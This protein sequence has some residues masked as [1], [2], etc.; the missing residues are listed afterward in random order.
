MTVLA[1]VNG[2]A[3]G[4]FGFVLLITL[5]ITYWASKRTSTA[6]DFWA[7]GRGITGAQN[8]FAIAGDYMSAASFL[9][10]AGLIY[11]YGFDGF[12]YSVGFLVA[13]LTV[14]FL[15][16]ERMRNAGKFTIADVLAFRLRQEPARVAAATGTLAVVAFYLIAQMVGAGLLIEALAGIDYRLAV[17]VTGTFMLVYVI[18]GGMIATTWVQIVK[19]V[20]L[21]AGAT[22][23]TVLVLGKVGFNPIELFNRAEREGMAEGSEFSLAPGTFLSSPLDT[24]SLGLALVLGTAGLP[25]I[26]MRFFT[27]PDAKAARK[28]V[29]WAV[30]LIGAFYIMTTA[31]GFGARAF[32][33]Q[34]GVEAAGASGNLAAPNLA[35]FLGGGEG[36]VGGD[37][38]LA[39]IAAIAF[40][41][42][43]AVVAGLV[44]SASGAVAHD[45]WTNV[46]RKNKAADP[47]KEEV[48]VARIAAVVIGAIAILIAAVGGEELNVSFMVGLAF[49]VAAAANFPALL[50]ALTWRRFNTTGALAG[51]FTGVVSSIGLVIISPQFWSGAGETEGAFSFYSLNNP[52]I[53]SIPLGFLAC[54]LGT[55]LSDERGNDR[56]F[57]ELYVRSETGLGA[58]K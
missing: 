29:V 39:V 37:I 44:I 40:A 1:A 32:L 25:H 6:T 10:I 27:V 47:E 13:F 22:V 7:A 52:G 16:A 43:L 38:F 34:G 58:E 50:L 49:A 2:E 26:L 55:V 8:G 53:I 57:H 20:L 35:Q 23:M 19:A 12:L 5:G 4:I 56:S 14:L 31:L 17:V 48:R 41:T 51:V 45:V 9:G 42:I 30:G 21:M 3:L 24:L 33:G 18:F 11:L 46:I 54:Y 15:L 36:T 28:S